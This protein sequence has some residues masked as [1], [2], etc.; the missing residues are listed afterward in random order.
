MNPSLTDILRNF[1]TP[2]GKLTQFPA[3]RKMKQY[4]L[5]YLAEKFQPDRIYTEL[6]VNELLGMYHTFH[7]P[8]T[9]R[10]ELYNGHFLDRSLDGRTYCLSPEQPE[11]Q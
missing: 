6:E 9:L 10:R 8:A 1:L 11:F 2:D 7:D 4:A 5:M 3:K